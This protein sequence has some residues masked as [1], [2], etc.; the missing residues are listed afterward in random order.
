MWKCPNFD[1]TVLIACIAVFLLAALV[2]SLIIPRMLLIS[3]KKRLFDIPDGRKVHTGSIP[4]LAGLTFFPAMLLSFL[5]LLCIQILISSQQTVN[6][7]FPLFICGLSVLF[8][9]GFKDDLIGVRYLHKFILQLIASAFLIASGN[10]VNYFYGMFGIYEIPL[11]TSVVFT[12]LLC[13]SIINS[14]NLIDGVDGLASV[15][16]GIASAALGFSFLCS[17]SYTYALLA[18]SIVGILISFLRYNFSSRKKIFMG[19]TGSLTLGYSLAFLVAHYCMIT[20]GESLTDPLPIVVSASVL[21][22]PLF[23]TIRVLAKR[24]IQHK[25]LFYPDKSHVHHKL[26]F[27]GHSHKKICIILGSTTVAHLIINIALY[28]YININLLFLF[29]IALGVIENLWLNCLVKR[30]EEQEAS[31]KKLF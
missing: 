15:L 14:I 27:M 11:L 31:T 7:S 2:E 25:P 30:K 9:T 19:D 22:V 26:V 28:R 8:M 12:L 13:L 6:I 18:F 23:D 1:Y 29:N 4:R 17:G 16:V 21:F 3:K 5:P 20:P 24:I 10:Y